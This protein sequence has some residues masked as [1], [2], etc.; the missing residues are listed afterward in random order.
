MRRSAIQVSWSTAR[1]AGQRG[2][3]APSDRRTARRRPS[4]GCGRSGRTRS[5]TI[6]RVCSPNT[7]PNPSRKSIGTP[8]TSAT[9]ASFN[10]FDRARENA[11]SW[12]AGTVPRAMPFI[13]TGIRNASASDSSAASACPHHTLVPAMITGRCA[14][15]SRSAA[16]AS[17]SPSALHRV[18][19]RGERTGFAR[20]VGPRRTRDPSGSRRTRHPSA[21]AGA[22]GRAQRVVDQPADRVCRLRGGGEPGQRRDER[23]MVDLL[24]RTLTPAQRGCPAAE[25]EQRRLV[26]LG[27]GHGTHP[28]GHAGTGGQRRDAGHPGHLRPALGRECRGLLVPGVDQPDALGTAS[29]VDGEQVPAGQGEDR[30]DAAGAQSAGDQVSGADLAARSGR[31]CSWPQHNHPMVDID[32]LI[33]G[34][35]PIGLT[36]ANRDWPAAAWHQD[37]RSHQDPPQYAK[38]IGV[39]PR[40]LEVF[41][42]MGGASPDPRRG[43]PDA[44]PDS[45]VGSS[46]RRTAGRLFVICVVRR[47]RTRW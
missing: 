37:R 5:A 43:H 3:G 42:G 41:E 14:P 39:Q 32:V 24:Q 2:Q 7:P 4:R 30:V 44:R 38:A 8:T 16:T 28:V 15:A 22:H 40:T 13:S 11:S 33:A 6:R 21:P 31:R 20:V 36:A 45:T 9:S 17:A 19:P 26:L 10:A 29:V 12:S 18:R 35:G 34:A 23:H 1:S 27:G 47:D 46:G 25:H